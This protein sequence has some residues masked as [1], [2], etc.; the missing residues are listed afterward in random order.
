MEVPDVTCLIFLA[1]STLAFTLGG[2]YLDL[3]H[4]TNHY[5]ELTE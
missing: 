3:N 5:S 2:L 4:P 1:Q